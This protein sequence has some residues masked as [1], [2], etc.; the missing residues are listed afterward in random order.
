MISTLPLAW[1]AHADAVVF[2]DTYAESDGKYVDRAVRLP[3][4]EMWS[5]RVLS[6]DEFRQLGIHLRFQRTANNDEVYAYFQQIFVSTHLLCK[7]FSQS[8]FAG[9]DYFPV[10]EISTYDFTHYDA[11]CVPRS[12][13]SDDLEV[14][15]TVRVPLLGLTTGLFLFFCDFVYPSD[16]TVTVDGNVLKHFTTCDTM[17]YCPRANACMFVPFF[18]TEGYAHPGLL[19]DRWCNKERLCGERFTANSEVVI[20]YSAP[21][22]KKPRTSFDKDVAHQ[23]VCF[24]IHQNAYE[25]LSNGVLQRCI[26]RTSFCYP[27]L[28]CTHREPQ[29]DNDT[30]F[31]NIVP[32]P[33]CTLNPLTKNW[34][35]SYELVMRRDQQC[36]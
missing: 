35:G 34:D 21:L 18:N 30:Q 19:P 2:A 1:L 8:A 15:R 27:T 25:R 26:P 22:G 7:T 29:S 20:T 36:V 12:N 14:R 31:W 23:L 33:T 13:G 4:F 16:L 17:K 5:N 28:G 32:S 10:Q 9:D 11:T 6:V 24:G 3:L